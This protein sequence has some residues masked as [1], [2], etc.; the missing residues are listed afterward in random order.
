ML[1]RSISRSAGSFGYDAMWASAVLITG[2]TM[3][4]YTVVSILDALV[5]RRFG[6]LA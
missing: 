4:V 2:F 1:F 5:D 6:A 3:L